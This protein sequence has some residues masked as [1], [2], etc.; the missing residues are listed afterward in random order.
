[1][2]N[3]IENDELSDEFLVQTAYADRASVATPIS[4]EPVE[5]L[6]ILRRANKLPLAELRT[7]SKCVGITFVEPVSR[8]DCLG[9]LDEA[10]DKEKILRFLEAHGV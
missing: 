1:M 10:D 4:W 9:A 2:Q 7:L 8:K 3:E 6:Q 5:F